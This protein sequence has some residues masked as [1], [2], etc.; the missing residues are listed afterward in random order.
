VGAAVLILTLWK[1]GAFPGKWSTTAAALL[2]AGIAGNLTDRLW[3]GYVID[4]L[5]FDLKF[6]M[7]PSFN[8]ADSCVVCAAI[9]LAASSFFEVPGKSSSK[10]ES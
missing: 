5:R 3:V 2:I 9:L 7:W 8:I 4:F 6:M 10:S 1:K